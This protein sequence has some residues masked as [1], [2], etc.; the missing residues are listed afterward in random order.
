MDLNRI[1]R[2]EIYHYMYPQ[3]RGELTFDKVVKRIKGTQ[4][5]STKS[6]LFNIIARTGYIELKKFSSPEEIMEHIYWHG[7]GGYVSGGLKAG[8]NFANRNGEVE[9]GGGYGELY[10]SISVSKSKNMASNFTSM[11][12]YG[13]VYP[14]LLR[15][16]ATV[17][18]MP[19][20]SDA[21]EIEDI[22]VDLW[23]KKVDAVKIGEW[24]NDSS[25]QELVVLNPKAVLKFQ[26]EGY[27]VYNKKRFTNPDISTYT[28]IYNT[29]QNNPAPDS[30][31][32]LKV[33]YPEQNVQEYDDSVN[34]DNS[35]PSPLPDFGDRIQS[36]S[37]KASTKVIMPNVNDSDAKKLIDWWNANTDYYHFKERGYNGLFNVV[38][39]L[40]E[41]E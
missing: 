12:R 17:E 21:N 28:A 15:K 41:K 35:S 34:M 40:P 33:Q 18:E 7:T 5:L 19:H 31:S 6:D 30:K 32:E 22:L 24:S 26:G 10:H 9:G 20:I 1:I 16:G 37:E 25:E 14:V 36:I 39:Q 13:M 27:Q 4:S 3:H 23:L 38:R 2:E 11:S 8:F 29:I